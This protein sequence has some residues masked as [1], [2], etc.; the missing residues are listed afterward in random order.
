MMDPINSFQFNLNSADG[1]KQNWYIDNNGNKTYDTNKILFDFGQDQRLACANDEKWTIA[2]SGANIP[3]SYYVINNNNNKIVVT[4]HSTAAANGTYTITE[5]NYDVYSLLTALT[6]TTTTAT[7]LVQQTNAT[8]FATYFTTTYDDVRQEYTFTS[9]SDFTFN[10]TS[11]ALKSLGF[12]KGTSVSSVDHSL[13]SSTLIN[14]GYTSTIFIQCSEFLNNGL[15][16]NN[17]NYSSTIIGTCYVT[18]N[19]PAMLYY[20]SPFEIKTFQK[21]LFLFTIELVDEDRNPICFNG[22]DWMMT[23]D[24]KKYKIRTNTNMDSLYINN[25]VIYGNQ[26]KRKK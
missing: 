2:I 8:L 5:G 22:L 10:S 24:L 6:N 26:V 12:V 3:L 17:L 11:T 19:P 23:L 15:D 7:E 9:T 25:Q 16:S 20:Q 13:S 18:Q 21:N 1:T 4:G 14:L